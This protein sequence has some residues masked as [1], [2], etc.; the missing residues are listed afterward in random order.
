MKGKICICPKTWREIKQ[1]LLAM[2]ESISPSEGFL[3][4]RQLVRKVEGVLR[5]V[6]KRIKKKPRT[7]KQ[8]AAT[9]KLIAFNKRR[10]R[11]R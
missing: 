2:D 1:A 6:R 3:S 7:A 9:K 11:R 4:G 5:K 10:R 8:R